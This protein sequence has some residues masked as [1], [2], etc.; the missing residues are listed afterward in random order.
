[1]MNS[2]RIETHDHKEKKTIATSSN[3]LS[4]KTCQKYQRKD[5]TLTYVIEEKSASKLIHEKAQLELYPDK[6]LV[7]SSLQSS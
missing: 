2:S 4:K 3:L 6:K 1:M 5:S 7:S